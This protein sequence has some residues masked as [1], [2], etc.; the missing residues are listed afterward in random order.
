MGKNIIFY[1]SGTGNCLKLSKDIAEALPDCGIVSMGTSREYVLVGEYDSIGFVYPV[2]FQ[3][4]PGKVRDFISRID[5]GTNKKTYI[6]AVATYGALAGNGVSQTAALLRGRGLELS[7]GN[8]VR[9]FS[10][11]IIFYNMSKKVD[12]VTEASNRA[13]VP[14]IDDIK[15]HRTRRTGKPN[16]LLEAYYQMRFK[17]VPEMDKYY[18]VS[19]GCVSCGICQRVCPVDNIGLDRGKPFFRHHCEQCVAC[20]QYCPKR[21][22]NFKNKTQKRRR[23]TNPYIN[24]NQLFH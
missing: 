17:S 21:A 16:P 4:I 14:V 18:T 24:S 9:M 7:Y 11:Y 3:G 13:A 23:Y 6:Y 5:F 20:I 1:F 15:H 10:N 19:D 8:T 2:Y 12:A 22:I